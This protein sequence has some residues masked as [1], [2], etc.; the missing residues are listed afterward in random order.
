MG[1]KTH[2]PPVLCTETITTTTSNTAPSPAETAVHTISARDIAVHKHN[3]VETQYESVY[4]KQRRRRLYVIVER[5]DKR[6]FL[7]R[8]LT[9]ETPVGIRVR[10]RVVRRTHTTPHRQCDRVM[11]RLKK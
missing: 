9:P 1:S 4:S 11:A 6:L 8:R 10:V 3:G 5:A 2:F 7:K